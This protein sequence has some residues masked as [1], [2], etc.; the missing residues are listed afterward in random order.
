MLSLFD[1]LT[2][3]MRWTNAKPIELQHDYLQFPKTG[4]KINFEQKRVK[5]SM[6]T[7]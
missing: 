6:L 1:N 5:C 3:L 7:A 2:S 4:W